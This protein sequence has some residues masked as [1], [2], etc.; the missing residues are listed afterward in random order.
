MKRLYVAIALLGFSTVLHAASVASRLYGN[1]QVSSVADSQDTT[2][3]SSDDADKLVGA[4]FL[5]APDRVQFGVDICQKPRFMA[6]HQRTRQLFRRDYRFEPKNMGLPDP[7]TQVK[8]SCEN[9]VDYFIYVK[10]KDAL[11]F[12]WKGF[13]LNAIRQR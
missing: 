3:M 4:N 6:T 13:F 7:V 9:P 1:W 10:G 12:Y 11:V 2:S 5:I 8:V